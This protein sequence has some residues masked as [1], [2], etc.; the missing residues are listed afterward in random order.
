M[1]SLI[2]A[3][4]YN[5]L[6]LC[7]AGRTLEIAQELD[8]DILM[9]PGTCI[10]EWEGRTCHAENFGGGKFTAVHYGWRRAPYSNTSA[11]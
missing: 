2:R 1:C 11:G 7:T 3:A 10:R 8:V 6:S 9:M 5:P 4:L